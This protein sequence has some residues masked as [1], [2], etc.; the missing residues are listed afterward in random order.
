MT[1]TCFAWPC[2]WTRRGMAVL[3]VALCALL[4]GCGGDSAE[5]TTGQARFVYVVNEGSYDISAYRADGSTGALT[6]VPGSPFAAGLSP[7][8]LAVDDTARFVYVANHGS[9]DVSAYTLNAAT[10]AL[11]PLAGAPYA[12]GAAPHAVAVV[13]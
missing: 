5:P 8:S 1:Q 9:N 2:S 6:P 13:R 7:S 3:C 10:G 4:S 11:T 12:A